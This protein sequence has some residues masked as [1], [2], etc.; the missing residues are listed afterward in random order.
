MIITASEKKERR[1]GKKAKEERK[2]RRG[3]AHTRPLKARVLPKLSPKPSRMYNTTQL[4]TL[5]CLIMIFLLLYTY[6]QI[7]RV[8]LEE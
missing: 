3:G 4:N 1:I 8:L 5:A 2:R 7:P 6:L